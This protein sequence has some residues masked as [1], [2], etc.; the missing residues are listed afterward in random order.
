MRQINANY[1]IYFNKKYKRTG[2]LWQGRYKEIASRNYAIIKALDDGYTQG[3]IA[4]YLGLS[5]AMVS[6]VFRADG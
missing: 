3:E 1:A 5:T 6:K 2:H 4:R